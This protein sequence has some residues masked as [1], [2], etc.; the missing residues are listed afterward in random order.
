[1]TASKEAL[2]ALLR[3]AEQLGEL[4]EKVVFVGGIVRCFLITDPAV[5]IDGLER[6]GG[7]GFRPQLRIR[8]VGRR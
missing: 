8:H 7:D 6:M 2:Y 5:D 1:M 3:V 4:R